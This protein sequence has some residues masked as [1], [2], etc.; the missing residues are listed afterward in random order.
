M[1]H[2]STDTLEICVMDR[3]DL[4]QAI[5]W[6]AAEGCIGGQKTS[7]STRRALVKAAISRFKRV[8][9]NALRSRTDQRRRTEVTIAIHALNRLLELGRPRSV[10]IA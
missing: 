4:D 6:A 10:R 7:G 5:D 9:G 2:A 1:A 8:I 3:T